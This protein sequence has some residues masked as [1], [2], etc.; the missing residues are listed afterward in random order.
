MML[1]FV[2]V[3]V[4]ALVA[5]VMFVLGAHVGGRGMLS[6]SVVILLIG[7]GITLMSIGAVGEA[8]AA[9]PVVH[10]QSLYSVKHEKPPDWTT[11][12]NDP[13]FEVFGGIVV[14]LWG[15]AGCIGYGFSKES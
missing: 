15:V 14:I 6:L 2:S 11:Q 10:K 4:A 8:E 9:P 13:Y 5:F 7:F 1:V 12:L 3:G